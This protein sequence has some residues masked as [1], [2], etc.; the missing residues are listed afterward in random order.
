[1]RNGAVPLGNRFQVVTDVSRVHFGD[2][3]PGHSDGIGTDLVESDG[4]GSGPGGHP[5]IV[6]YR[7]G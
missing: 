1:M 4:A 7:A 3:T 2:G 5:P 6:A